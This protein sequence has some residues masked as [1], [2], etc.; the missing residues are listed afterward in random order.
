MFPYV[1]LFGN[2]EETTTQREKKTQTRTWYFMC[3]NSDCAGRASAPSNILEYFQMHGS[4]RDITN[5]KFQMCFALE[6]VEKTTNILTTI[7]LI[8]KLFYLCVRF[9]NLTAFKR[10]LHF[11]KCDKYVH[12][13][14]WYIHCNPSTRP[15]RPKSNWH[16]ISIQN[17]YIFIYTL[18]IT[19]RYCVCCTIGVCI[20]HILLKASKDDT[21]TDEPAKWTI[22]IMAWDGQEWRKNIHARQIDHH[23]FVFCMYKVVRGLFVTRNA[24]VKEIAIAIETMTFIWWKSSRNWY[25]HVVNLNC[26][27]KKNVFI[28][29]LGSPVIIAQLEIN[30]LENIA[31]TLLFFVSLYMKCI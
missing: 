4:E 12:V 23:C 6:Y 7:V 10:S 2:C 21:A 5:S 11:T 31:N 1:D 9:I 15:F 29:C 30:R 22:Y 8:I 13:H 28:A 19:Y 24:N 16:Q 26:M 17:S 3:L 14:Y 18:D 27:W 20:L 25:F